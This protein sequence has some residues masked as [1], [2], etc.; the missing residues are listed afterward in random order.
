MVE[1]ID[2]GLK[3]VVL[4]GSGCVIVVVVVVVVFVFERD[5]VWVVCCN[6][7]VMEGEGVFYVGVNV[8]K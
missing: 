7:E 5:V 8:D 3:L 6:V 4:G 1:L 2:E